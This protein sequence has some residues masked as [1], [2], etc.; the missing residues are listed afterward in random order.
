M[1]LDVVRRQESNKAS[2]ALYFTCVWLSHLSSVYLTIYLKPKSPPYPFLLWHPNAQPHLTAASW[3]GFTV[4]C[5]QGRQAGQDWPAPSWQT[6]SQAFGIARAWRDVR[7][8]GHPGENLSCR[9]TA[10]S[11]T[12]VGRGVCRGPKSGQYNCAIPA[13]RPVN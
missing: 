4:K 2:A 12:R 8:D 13:S 5:S 6:L 3:L 11:C 10:S 7:E 1:E 9:E